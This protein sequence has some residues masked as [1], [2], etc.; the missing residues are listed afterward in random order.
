M[1]SSEITPRSFDRISLLLAAPL[2]VLV[3]L[4][5]ASG[6][7]IDARRGF[8][9]IALFLILLL[10]L[11]RRK[12][13]R[14]RFVFALFALFPAG[15]VAVLFF[16]FTSSERRT[17][18][19]LMTGIGV[20]SLQARVDRME[21]LA[22]RGAEFSAEDKGFLK[23]LYSCF[24]KGGRLLVVL[25]QSA[26]LMERY[27]EASGQPLV[28]GPRVFVGSAPV[29]ERMGR[30]R[31]ELLERMRDGADPSGTHET[32]TF[33]M[34]DASFP[35]S[36]VA[37]YLGRLIAHVERAPGDRFKI[38]WRAELPWKWPSFAEI[39][40]NHGGDGQAVRFAIPTPATFLFGPARSL[41]ITDGLGAHLEKL[42][43]AKPF[44]ASARWEEIWDPG[45][46]EP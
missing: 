23:D 7:P 37:L 40:A 12:E 19:T 10:A 31:A 4:A 3:P 45:A 36:A 22:L 21:G 13:V 35:E 25:R 11:R 33:Y 14:W 41:H 24:A 28:I 30:L 20:P 16:V 38:L 34:P 8:A 6:I 15:F 32:E 1:R 39:A 17:A 46:G 43:L 5:A 26:D 2:L 44:L 9:A 29:R 18:F 27:L 42:G